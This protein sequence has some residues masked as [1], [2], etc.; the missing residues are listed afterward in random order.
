MLISF[1]VLFQSAPYLSITV[2][3]ALILSAAFCLSVYLAFSRKDSGVIGDKRI[4]WYPTYRPWALVAVVVIPMTSIILLLKEGHMSCGIIATVA[5]ILEAI[6]TIGATVL[7]LVL[8]LFG[9]QVAERRFGP[10]LEVKLHDPQGDLIERPDKKQTKAR[11]Y[12]VKVINTGRTAA[13]RVKVRIV[14]LDRKQPDGSWSQEKRYVI[15]VQL[16]WAYSLVWRP[17][18]QFQASLPT[19]WTDDDY[20]CDLAYLNEGEQ[21]V[22]IPS[23]ENPTNFPGHVTEGNPVRVHLIASAENCR[24]KS[25]LV[26]EISWDGKWSADGDEMQKYLVVG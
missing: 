18:E 7:A 14:R 11:Y 10:K 15:P 22:V 3:V 13:K 20:Y 17:A 4:C 6:G 21:R 9:R 8:A 26:V 19:I 16:Q 25:P 5:Q 12:H 23:Y 24:S 2:S 1:I